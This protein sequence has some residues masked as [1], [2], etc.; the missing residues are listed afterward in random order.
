MKKLLPQS[1]IRSA[2]KD[3]S[4]TPV[5][6]TVK[7]HSF[8]KILLQASDPETLP[9]ILSTLSRH[10]ETEVC[11][12]V[13][14][15]PN[16]PEIV[17]KDLWIRYPLA[18]LVNPIVAFRFL[19]GSKS[20][21]KD[22]PPQV[23]MALYTTLCSEGRFSEMADHVPESTR[24]EWL[25]HNIKTHFSG[26]LSFAK[27][28]YEHLAIDPS[29]AVRQRAAESDCLG[30]DFVLPLAKDEDA[31]VRLALATR[32]SKHRDGAGI[33]KILS[34][35]P[36]V[37]VRKLIAHSHFLPPSAHQ[38]LAEDPSGDV[39][40]TLA[41]KSGC[42]RREEGGWRTLVETGQELS[43]LVASNTCCPKSVLLDLVS[44]FAADVRLSAWNHYAFEKKTTH[45]ERAQLNALLADPSRVQERA[46]VAA[47]RTI[48]E[49]ISRRLLVAEVEVTRALAGN[50]VISEAERIELLLG[51][52]EQTSVLALQCTDSDLV[53]CNAYNHPSAA[54][55]ACIPPK[56][57]KAIQ[58]LPSLL[59]DPS[60][61][62][63]QSVCN[64]LTKQTGPKYR[65]SFRQESLESLSQDPV[66]AIRAQVAQF[67]YAGWEI[68]DRL[69]H[70]ASVK[71]RVQV[72]QNSG[73]SDQTLAR[74][75]Q[76]DSV[77]VRVK[78][79]ERWYLSN[80][81]LGRLSK[82]DA[83]EVRVSVAGC[84]SRFS[85]AICDQLPL[86]PSW[87][88]KIVPY[89]WVIV[90]WATRWP[91]S[92][93]DWPGSVTDQHHQE[94]HGLG[95]A[96]MLKKERLLHLRLARDLSPQVRTAVARS[97][98]T[99]PEALAALI[100]DQNKGVRDALF[101]RS[102]PRT[103]DQE[104]RWRKRFGVE[105]GF[106]GNHENPYIRAVAANQRSTGKRRLRRLAEDDCWYVRA[107]AL[108]TL[109]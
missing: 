6:Q 10:Q 15:N 91:R 62:V 85:R 92:V 44:H 100:N 13:A 5:E 57:G 46:V 58:M 70:D 77:E 86:G 67:L 12:R 107:I 34:L 72:A 29:S 80:A 75:A 94:V 33:C 55:R 64:Y 3:Q 102:L 82:D 48:N 89:T 56:G 21:T 17:L 14:E 68:L 51:S 32:A 59:K 73:A 79:A 78:V 97:A 41:E 35:D 38:R 63:R 43:L 7:V 50:R 4:Q 9:D 45:K 99:S 19:E 25:N 24:C 74:L 71:V 106:L 47:N 69:S 98:W 96:E 103:W 16:T 105:D 76:D 18:M 27:R 66:V 36:S 40:A 20:F 101:D 2:D 88:D 42:I 52:D 61:L 95:V 49:T 84:F 60:A 1:A 37:E 30:F 83:V 8:K 108:R 23:S 90:T 31:K 81:I 87:W 26:I 65:S 54:V 11:R 28:L 104:R 39:R 93:R 109:P 53:L 22:L